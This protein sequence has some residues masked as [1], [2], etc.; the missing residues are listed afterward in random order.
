[1]RTLVLLVL[2]ACSSTPASLPLPSSVLDSVVD[3]TVDSQA[4]RHVVMAVGDSLTLGAPELVGGYRAPLQQMLPEL[5]FVGRNESVGR[6]EGYSG[7]TIARIRMTVLPIVDTLQPDTILL[8]AGTNDI[9]TNTDVAGILADYAALAEE[10]KAHTSV[11]RVIVSNVPFRAG[12]LKDETIAYNAGLPAAFAHASPGITLV[13][14]CSTVMF[15][16]D[17]G[18]STHPNAAGYLKIAGGWRDPAK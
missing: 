13:D 12:A 2:V 9:T 8:M 16:A 15:P 14:T 18:D 11:Q 1:M 4:T 6:H 17:F 10:F 3:G 7:Y 5:M